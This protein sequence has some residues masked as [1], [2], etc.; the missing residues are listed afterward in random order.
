MTDFKDA[1]DA[2][3]TLSTKL[4]SQRPAIVFAVMPNGA[5]AATAIARQTNAKIR[6]LIFDRNNGQVLADLAEIAATDEIWVA[7]DGVESGTAAR[8]IGAHFRTSGYSN[9]HLAVPVCAKDAAAE[10]QFLYASVIAAVMPL[11]TRSLHWH[12]EQMPA[13]ALAEAEALIQPHL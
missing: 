3:K 11:M 13:L 10:L 6:P 5:P 2:A 12:Y 4:P 8:A 7:D 1:F 9:V